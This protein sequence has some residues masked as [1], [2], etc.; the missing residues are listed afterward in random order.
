[1]TTK[2]GNIFLYLVVIHSLQLRILMII[3]YIYTNKI[4]L[5][6][7]ILERLQDIITRNYE[8]ISSSIG[9]KDD[10]TISFIIKTNI[11]NNEKNINIDIKL[12]QNEIYNI[13]VNTYTENN[14]LNEYHLKNFILDLI[15]KILSDEHNEE[16]IQYTIRTYSRIFNSSPIQQ[17]ILI[18][19]DYKTL[20]KP[21]VW[22]TRQEPLTEQIVIY[23]IEIKAINVDHARSIA[24]NYSKNLN[25]YLS[26]LL[27]VGF[28]LI[29]SEFRVFVIKDGIQIN[30]KRYR[31]GFIDL[32]LGLLVQNNLNGLINLYNM[33]EI[34]SFHRGKEI[35]NFELEGIENSDSF[36]F[37]ASDSNDFLEKLFQ[38]HSIK[39]SNQNKKPKE[40]KI[41]KTF[42]FPN[43]EIE[44]PNEIRRYF[45][46]ISSLDKNIK[47][48]FLSSARMYNL[49][50]IFARQE[51]TV[52][53]SYK[54]CA[55]ETLATFEKISF[56][57]FM[58]KYI[59]KLSD[60]DKKLLDYYYS[61]RSGHFHSGKF[62]FGEF[63][64]SLLAE[65]NF[66]L[67]EK[68]KEY[69]QFN[70]LIREALISWV[71]ENILNA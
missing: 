16:L 29:T 12:N 57:E 4:K 31:T 52:E 71:E 19:G 27:D 45:K 69:F 3:K 32:E 40:I 30:L 34:N 22:T 33:D 64:V 36:V 68:T 35:L 17:E 39:K 5:K 28:E 53:K 47:E 49:S 21:Y 24:Y 61:I 14:E 54:V 67:K 8:V 60:D 56:S 43:L 11:N 23:D 66:L 18:N 26:V 25:A 20:I 1:M 62:Y 44:I 70:N 48:V 50:L 59:P 55:I 10:K 42:H 37:N 7:T 41:K 9:D 46:N 6:N 13:E 51:A 15:S 38:E 58:R 2:V 65:V 63:D